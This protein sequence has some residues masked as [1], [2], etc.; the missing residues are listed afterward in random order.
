MNAAVPPLGGRVRR[1]GDRAPLDRDGAHPRREV[2]GQLEGAAPH[3]QPAVVLGVLDAVDPRRQLAAGAQKRRVERA[4]PP[5]AA[6]GQ[7]R[8]LEGRRVLRIGHLALRELRERGE[9]PPAPFARG[10]GYALVDVV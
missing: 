2:A 3:A 5:A 9:L 7:L 10:V 8:A 6:A 1:E 4:Q